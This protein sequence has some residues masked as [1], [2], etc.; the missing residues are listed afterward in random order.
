MA[1]RHWG[2]VSG[3]TCDPSHPRGWQKRK[4]EGIS[5]KHHTLLLSLPWKH[6]R[7]AADTAKCSGQHL[8]TWSLSLSK[9]LQLGA[10]GQ[11]HLRGLSGKGICRRGKAPLL[12]RGEE[13]G[14]TTIGNSL[15]LEC[16]CPRALRGR[17]GSGT[18]LAAVESPVTTHSLLALPIASSSLKTH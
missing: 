11:H 9:T 2:P 3:P 4:K 7:P 17:D 8:D 12:R 6:T 1:C 14:R 16:T 10:A 15:H 13:E 5:T 18:A